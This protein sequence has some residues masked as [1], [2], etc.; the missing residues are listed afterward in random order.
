VE[1]KIEAGS[2]NNNKKVKMKKKYKTRFPMARIK[3]DN[4]I[5]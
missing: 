4:A 3:K 5:R 2:N 1:R